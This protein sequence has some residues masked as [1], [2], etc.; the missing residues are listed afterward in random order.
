M[1]RRCAELKRRLRSA[2]TYYLFPALFTAVCVEVGLRLFRL[3]VLTRWLGISLQTAGKPR[4]RSA[5]PAQLGHL[6]ACRY[7]AARH[8]L[9][10]WPRSGEDTCLRFALVAGFLLRHRHPVMCLGVA[11]GRRGTRA[12]AWIF[13]DDMVFDPLSE[14]YRTLT[15]PG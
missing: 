12:H 10:L 13:V 11:R 8:V 6:D 2:T 14:T 5:R 7:H 9:R 1:N 15:E 4:G 3:P